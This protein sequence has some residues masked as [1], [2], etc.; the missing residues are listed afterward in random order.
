MGS[1]AIRTV[2]ISEG[3]LSA[4]DVLAFSNTSAITGSW[5]NSTG[6]LTLSGSDT[7][8]N[9]EAALESVTYNDTSENPHTGDLTI[10]WVVNDGDADSAAVTSTVTVAAV[11]D[12]PS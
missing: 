4:E 6:V 1:N 8:A 9:Y 2:T 5:N 11:N 3:F 10:S 12:A 7:L